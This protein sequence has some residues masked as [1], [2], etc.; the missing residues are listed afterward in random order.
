MMTELTNNEPLLYPISLGLDGNLFLDCTIK[1]GGS[2]RRSTY[3][4]SCPIRVFRAEWKLSDGMSA[5]LV[6]LRNINY[7]S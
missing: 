1:K 6:E 2:L 4:D 7:Q 3:F 5:A